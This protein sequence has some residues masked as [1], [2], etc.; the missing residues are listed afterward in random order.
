MSKKRESRI[1]RSKK[2][3][4]R[5]MKKKMVRLVVFRS[6]SN[7]YAQ[8][9]NDRAEVLVSA[10]TLEPE[11]RKE[12][13]NGGNRAAAAMVGKIV[14]AKASKAGVSKVAFDRSGYNYHGRVKA[15]A[16]AA[17]EAGLEF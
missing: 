13:V 2:T 14:A 7:M 3:R 15:L 1:R 10:S 16:E 17:R 8:V 12:V 9:I 11:I 5:I 4:I 6:N